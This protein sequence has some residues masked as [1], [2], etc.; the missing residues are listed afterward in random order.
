MAETEKK[1]RTLPKAGQT[2]RRVNG[3]LEN[4]PTKRPN[5]KN[6]EPGQYPPKKKTTFE[7]GLIKGL[8][9]KRKK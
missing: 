1:K 2:A 7:E 8:F 9:K 4:S 6:Y 3:R 5:M